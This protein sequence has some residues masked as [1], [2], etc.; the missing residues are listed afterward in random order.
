MT[1]RFLYLTIYTHLLFAVI[2][3]AAIWKKCDNAPR[4]L[5][6]QCFHVAEKLFLGNHDYQDTEHAH[7]SNCP[8]GD[9]PFTDSDN[10]GNAGNIDWLLELTRWLETWYYFYLTS[11]EAMFCFM[12]TSLSE[13]LL[14]FWQPPKWSSWFAGGKTA[15]EHSW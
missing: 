8:H 5:Q 4:F 14:S 11:Y 1:L 3:P 7:P 9:L 15:S 13:A 10:L 6:H 2:L 12:H